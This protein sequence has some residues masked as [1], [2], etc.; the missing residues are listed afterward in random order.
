MKKFEELLFFYKNQ[1]IY[2]Y[3]YK[4]GDPNYYKFDRAKELQKLK[5]MEDRLI[6]MKLIEGGEL[7]KQMR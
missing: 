5:E 4:K 1:V 7:W 2:F 6:N 3:G